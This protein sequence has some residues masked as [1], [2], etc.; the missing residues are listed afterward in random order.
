MGAYGKGYTNGEKWADF[1][2]LCDFV[3]LL[4][5]TSTDIKYIDKA[6]THYSLPAN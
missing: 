6:G 5:S 3:H 4:I 2:E 1:T